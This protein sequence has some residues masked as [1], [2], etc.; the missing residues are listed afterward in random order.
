[1]IIITVIICTAIYL[2]LRYIY[3][4]WERKNIPFISPTIPFGNLASVILRKSSFGINI[5]ELY[6]KTT[7][8]FVGIY[9]LFRPAI[10]V[11]DFD[12]IKKILSVDS[13]SFHDRGIYCNP[14]NDPLSENLFA[15][16]GKRWKDMR[17]KLSPSFTATKIKNVMMPGIMVES[18]KLLKC[19]NE[20][21]ESGTV[22]E[23]KDLA[24]KYKFMIL[25]AVGCCYF[26]YFVIFFVCLQ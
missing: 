3:S 11:R 13:A 21:A 26:Y 20:V 18:D 14:K 12:L 23:M 19:I 16:E 24:A 1:M 7:E 22:A 17:A 15:L 5:Y 10:L 25:L 6:C 2:L 9:L 8:P 4:H